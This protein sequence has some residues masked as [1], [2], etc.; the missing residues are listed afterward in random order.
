MKTWNEA[1]NA[2]IKVHLS[3]P[4]KSPNIRLNALKNIEGFLNEIY[5]TLL[6]DNTIFKK[7]NEGAILDYYLKLK[8]KPLN[9][10]EKS[11]IHGLYKFS[12]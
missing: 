1:K 9:G 8:G 10:A 5:K 2:Y 12:L 11:V 4:L 7:Y 3:K 6:K